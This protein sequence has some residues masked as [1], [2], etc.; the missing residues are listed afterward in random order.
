MVFLIPHRMSNPAVVY[1][2][3]LEVFVRFVSI[4]ECGFICLVIVLCLS[5]C[6]GNLLVI[7]LA[8][9]I[10]LVFCDGESFIFRRAI[11]TRLALAI[12][13]HFLSCDCNFLV[14]WHVIVSRFSFH[15]CNLLG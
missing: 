8:I 4:G 7:C 14:V 1:Y 2:T 5:F 12:E 11:V 3:C 15:N 9:V 13:I 10:C 6:S